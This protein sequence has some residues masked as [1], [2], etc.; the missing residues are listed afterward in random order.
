MAAP[1]PGR[2][3]RGRHRQR[4]DGEDR[5]DVALEQRAQRAPG[6][7]DA[8]RVDLLQVEQ[9]L[10]L[11]RGDHPPRQVPGRAG[12]PARVSG[13]VLVQGRHDVGRARPGRP[14]PGAQLVP[15]ERGEG[16]A[17]QLQLALGPQVLLQEAGVLRPAEL[18]QGA[19]HDLAD[20]QS[21]PGRPQAGAG[22]PAQL[23]DQLLAALLEPA[24]QGRLGHEL[25]HRDA[26]VSCVLHQ[27]LGQPQGFLQGV[28][29]I[30]AYRCHAHPGDFTHN[31]CAAPMETHG[32]GAWT[33]G[34]PNYN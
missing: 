19:Q 33:N 8:Q 29:E 9:A 21:R 30:L 4:L 23:P 2:G 15:A 22:S 11:R 14:L 3:D 1:G 27:L 26:G 12:Q 6:A 17:V 34:V 28:R 13:A 10:G 32:I 25:G 16:A 31:P 20:R 7:A 5:R 24:E 18:F